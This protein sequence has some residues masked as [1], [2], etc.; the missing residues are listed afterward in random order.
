MK[1][2]TNYALTLYFLY[3]ETNNENIDQRHN[4][5]KRNVGH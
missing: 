3:T 2:V 5:E 4:R 1:K